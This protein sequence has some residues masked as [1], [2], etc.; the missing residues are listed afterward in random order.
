MSI[1]ARLAMP[2]PSAAIAVVD[3]HRRARA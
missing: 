2:R 1:F 3:R